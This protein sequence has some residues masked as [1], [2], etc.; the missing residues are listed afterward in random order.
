MFKTQNA[1]QDHVTVTRF[2]L[3]KHEYVICAT[4]SLVHNKHKRQ[5]ILKETS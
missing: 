2:G 4:V 1:P 3:C 5:I